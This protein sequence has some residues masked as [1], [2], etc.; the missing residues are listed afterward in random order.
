M[1]QSKQVVVGMLGLLLVF[2]GYSVFTTVRANNLERRLKRLESSNAELVAQHRA[3]INTMLQA[4]T[5]RV[6][7]VEAKVMLHRE[8]LGVAH[9]TASGETRPSDIEVNST[10][11]GVTSK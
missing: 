4:E 5:S 10:P 11:E 6:A 1:K 7:A 8:N 9:A 3:L 2:L